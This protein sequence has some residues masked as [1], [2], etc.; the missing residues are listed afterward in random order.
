[1]SSEKPWSTKKVHF[2]FTSHS[3]EEEFERVWQI[4]SVKYE[5]IFPQVPDYDSGLNGGNTATDI[6]SLY[7]F[8]ETMASM[9]IQPVLEDSSK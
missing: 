8:I 9:I 2:D 1:M 7:F 6:L 3:L 5:K 4:G